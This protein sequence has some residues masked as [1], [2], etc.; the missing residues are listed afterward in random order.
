MNRHD[1]RTALRGRGLARPVLVLALVALVGTLFPVNA[2]GYWSSGHAGSSKVDTVT[3][4]IGGW[5]A[6][7]LLGLSRHLPDDVRTSLEATLTPMELSSQQGLIKAINELAED[8]HF[9]GGYLVADGYDELFTNG[10]LDIQPGDVLIYTVKDDAGGCRTDA[11][12]R[13]LVEVI[14]IDQNVP[15]PISKDELTR[16]IGGS[17]GNANHLSPHYLPS[18]FYTLSTAP[19][20]Y[21]G[22]LYL[23]INEGGAS[24]SSPATREQWF[25][26]DA[27]LFYDPLNTYPSQ[28][29]GWVVRYDNGS[30]EPRYY[31]TRNWVNPQLAPTTDTGEWDPHGPWDQLPQVVPGATY[32]LNEVVW[33]DEAGNHRFWRA[34]DTTNSLPSEDTARAGFWQEFSNGWI[35]TGKLSSHYFAH[36]TYAKDDTVIY[37]VSATLQYR[38]YKAKTAVPADQPPLIKSSTGKLIVNSDYWDRV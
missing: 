24:N 35:A 2:H 10:D 26:L 20:E 4:H 16:R 22:G 23:P 27:N 31:L 25:K 21:E 29:A 30:G 1:T 38:Y 12:G 3:I 37:G 8:P 28:I 13:C 14:M 32:E 19:V 5:E 6:E 18:I 9:T 34:L 11:G 33:T 15:N 7:P 36:N 17:W